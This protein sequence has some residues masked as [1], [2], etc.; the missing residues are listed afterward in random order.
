MAFASVLPA[1]SALNTVD[2]RDGCCLLNFYSG[3]LLLLLLLLLFTLLKQDVSKGK[4]GHYLE[5]LFLIY[6]S[7]YSSVF[8][9]YS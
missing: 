6:D 7:F 3:L 4:K 5:E 1:L 9:E 8:N 2:T